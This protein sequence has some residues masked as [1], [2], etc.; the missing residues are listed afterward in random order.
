MKNLEKIINSTDIS[1][2]EII[3]E[4]VFYPKNEKDIKKIIKVTNKTKTPLIARG[5]G[6]STCGQ[7]I[8]SGNIVNFSKMNKI[9][10]IKKDYVDVEPGIICGDLNKKLEKFNKTF[11]VD[12]SSSKFCSIAGMVSNNAS[13]IHSY[14]YGDTKDYVLGLEGYF[15][16]GTFFSTIKNIN[17]DKLK[18]K[19]KKIEPEY[20]KI[21]SFLPETTKDASGYMIKNY[22][23]KN[24]DFNQ[25]IV[26][27][28]GTLAIITKI[29]LKIINLPKTRSTILAQYD[30]LEKALDGAA[31]SKQIKEI[32]A[33]ELADEI[34]IDLSRKH[35]KEA[36]EFLLPVTKATVLFEIDN[37]DD[38]LLKKILEKNAIKVTNAKSKKERNFLW[39][40]RK[41]ASPLL[42]RPDGNFITLRFIEDV[43]VP[44]DKISIFYEKEKEILRNYDT[45]F[46][47][48]LGSGHFHIN[49][50]MD[51]KDKKFK[52][53]FHN[54]S[55]E[56]FKLVNKLKGTITAEHGDG[57]LRPLYIKKINPEL[58]NFFKKIKEIFDP[59]YLLNPNNIVYKDENYD[60]FNDF[61]YN[62][63]TKYDFIK[64]PDLNKC[65]GCNECITFCKSYKK[66]KK[67]EDKTRSRALV[68]RALM[69][70]ELV[71]TKNL[72]SCNHC[73]KCI[74]N[75]PS[76]VDIIALTKIL[77]ENN[78]KTSFSYK[79]R[80]ILLLP[81]K[82]LLK[83]F[84]YKK[85]KV[86]LHNFWKPLFKL[87]LY[88]NDKDL[89]KILK[90]KILKSKSKIINYYINYLN[91][92]PNS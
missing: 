33:I 52:E 76:G 56:T 8:G 43:A 30:S 66:T 84:T 47:G 23:E 37:G 77:R 69:R 1:I 79:I 29:R 63:K 78:L 24:K 81:M 83:Y 53:N 31:L 71:S 46:F 49:P 20:N 80:K 18:E 34:V 55:L 90:G 54:I 7:G 67:E 22:F 87:N 73:F 58:Y 12:P 27:S 38:F 15:I 91:N 21:K 5:C 57:K 88:K 25:I 3:P 51:I 19:L 44:T 72:E 50:R 6:T 62:Y 75:C 9:I 4:N 10:S 42:S 13:G 17:L 2:L 70:G 26:G 32:S 86:E 68:I 74:G 85:D 28:E 61:K 14:L 59:N 35:Y 82:Y 48:H 40:I 92:L 64:V 36:N 41:I 39:K 89:D 11:P 16:D 45:A 65:H 60:F